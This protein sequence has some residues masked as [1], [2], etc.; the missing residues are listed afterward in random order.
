MARPLTPMMSASTLVSFTL[1][2]SRVFWMRRVCWAISRT[3]C[4]TG[5]GQVAQL[6]HGRGRHEAAADETVREQIGD[7]GGVVD[8]ALAAG[9]VA[10]V[11]GV[12]EDELEV[13]VEHM[14]D[15]LPVH[16]AGLHGDVRAAMGG[17]PVAE[18]QQLWRTRAEGASV[19]GDGLPG[20]RARERDD[21]LLVHVKAGTRGMNDVHSH[22]LGEMA[23]AWSPRRRSLDS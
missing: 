20:A 4:F 12:G 17:E 1:A 2:V 23:S 14:P 16:P 11:H 9:D 13:A 21:G 15:R 5:A 7:P 19:V 18:G 8:V 10:D 6:L 22:L 3:S